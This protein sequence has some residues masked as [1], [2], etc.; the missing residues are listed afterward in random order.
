MLNSEQNPERSVATGDD[1]ST[2]VWLKIFIGAKISE[3]RMQQ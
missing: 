1:R 2:D 3:Q